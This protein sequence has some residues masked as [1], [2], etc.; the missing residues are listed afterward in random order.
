[1]INDLKN[2]RWKGIL[3]PIDKGLFGEAK[4]IRVDYVESLDGTGFLNYPIE[5]IRESYF[6]DFK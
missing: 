5:V 3:F 4:P 6:L 2:Y 1:M